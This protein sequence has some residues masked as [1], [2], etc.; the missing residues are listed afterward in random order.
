MLRPIAVSY[1]ALI[2]GLQ[3]LERSLSEIHRI[4]QIVV[5]AVA[6][7]EMYFPLELWREV[8]PIARDDKRQIVVVAPVFRDVRVDRAGDLGEAIRKGIA[9]NKPYL[10]DVDIAADINPN[11]LEI[12]TEARVEPALAEASN[13]AEPVQFER[14]GYFYLDKDSTPQ[15][16]VCNRTVGL[17]DTWAKLQSNA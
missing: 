7:V 10:I 5:I 14:Q 3:R 17:R 16:L 13:R 2:S 11:S 15:H 1:R 4:G 8:L 12:L 9:A 6:D